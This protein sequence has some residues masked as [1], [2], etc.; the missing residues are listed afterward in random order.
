VRRG[1]VQ[2]EVLEGEKA[3]VFTDG[4]QLVVTVN[5]KSDRSRLK[6]KVPYALVASLEVSQAVGI[7]VYDEVRARLRARVAIASGAGATP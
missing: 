4:A 7:A 1:T 6:E 2:H 3:S 5:C